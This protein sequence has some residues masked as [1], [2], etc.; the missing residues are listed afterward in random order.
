MPLS[1]LFQK[2]LMAL[3]L[4]LIAISAQGNGSRPQAPD[5]IIEWNALLETMLPVG[6]LLQPRQYAMLHVAMFDAVN[7]IERRYGRYHT[8]VWAAPIASSEAAAAQA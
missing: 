6:G 3:G 7:S 4:G 5:V 2:L 8:S 1:R